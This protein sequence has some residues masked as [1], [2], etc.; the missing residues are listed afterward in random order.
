MAQWR[1]E[2]INLGKTVSTGTIATRINNSTAR[3]LMAQWRPE[4][5]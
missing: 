1:P 2:K 4:L 5:I 3:H